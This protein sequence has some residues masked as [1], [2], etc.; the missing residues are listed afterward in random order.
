MIVKLNNKIINKKPFNF[1][2]H[3]AWCGRK[4]SFYWYSPYN[5]YIGG[6]VQIP[7]SLSEGYGYCSWECMENSEGDNGIAQQFS[8]TT[9]FPVR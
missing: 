2:T 1:K 9:G 6:F 8:Q 3:C 5:D 4:S 7:Y